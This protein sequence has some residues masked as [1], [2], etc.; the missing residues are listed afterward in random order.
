[1]VKKISGLVSSTKNMESNREFKDN[2]NDKLDAW[3]NDLDTNGTQ[4]D[5][6]PTE[7]DKTEVL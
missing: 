3:E 2:H 1:M 6:Q 7:D 4:S 5:V